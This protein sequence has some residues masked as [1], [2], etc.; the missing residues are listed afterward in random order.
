MQRLTKRTDFVRIS[1]NKQAIFTPGFI[2]QFFQRQAEEH[3]GMLYP[4]ARIGFTASRK[5]GNAVKRNFAKRRMR[6]L[7][8][9]I[10]PMHA[11][12]SYDYVCVARTAILTRPFPQLEEDFR[13]AALRLHQSPPRA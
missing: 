6:M 9:S 3:T 1:R 2:L 10:L 8:Q 11:R 12:D 7:V 4:E 5:V 13:Q